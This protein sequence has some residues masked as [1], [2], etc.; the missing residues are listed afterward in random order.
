MIAVGL[1]M[2]GVGFVL[3]TGFAIVLTATHGRRT[4][5]ELSPRKAALWGGLIGSAIPV[6]SNLE[7]PRNASSA[8][9]R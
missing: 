5:E 1:W 7:T 6:L 9:V 3:A 4:L 8:A 2:G